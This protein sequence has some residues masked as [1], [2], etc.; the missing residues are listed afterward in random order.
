MNNR[1]RLLSLVAAGLSISFIAAAC[2]DSGSSSGS[3]GA[4]TAA[5]AT[6]G[7]A[8]TTAAPETTAAGEST[9][10]AAAATTAASSGSGGYAIDAS[11]CPSSSTQ[12]LAAGSTIKVGFSAP[13]TGPLAGFGLIAD[14]LKAVFEK[15]NAAGGIDGHKLELDTK[16]DAYDPAKTKTNVAEFLQQDK[17][18]ISIIQVGTPNVAA[19]RDDYDKACIPQAFVGTGFPAWGDPKN[20][21]FTVGGILAYNTEA[22]MWAEYI[23]KV[24]PGAKVAQLVYNNDF[25]KSYQTQFEAS[26]KEKGLTITATKLH[27]PTSTLTNEVTALIASSP[28]IIIGETT[29]VFCGTLAR[30]ARQGGFTGPIIVSS[31]CFSNQFLGTP[32]V[33]DAAKDVFGIVQG[34]DPNDPQWKDDAGVKQYFADVKQFNPSAK[35]EISSVSTGYNIGSALVVLLQNAAK[36]S[37]GLSEVSMANAMWNIDT[38]LPLG[39]PGARYKINGDKD[40]YPVEYAE[41]RQY[42]P[43]TKSFKVTG[44]TFDLEGQTGVFKAAG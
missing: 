1:K 37:G 28:D 29:A 36:A 43:A 8:V 38:E 34:K 21:P 19:V 40:A 30:L 32:E 5:A 31:T 15:Q 25:G 22:K 33:G 26:A 35:P 3:S 23:A 14:G 16:D 6:T 13:L 12:P 17:I 42:D 10:S 41:M 39:L 7:A 44:N 27:E 9:T 20:H 4:T 2:G 24:K 18:N 11:N